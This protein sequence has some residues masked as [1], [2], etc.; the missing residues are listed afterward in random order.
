VI[1][2]RSTQPQRAPPLADT[3]AGQTGFD[4]LAFMNVVISHHLRD[5]RAYFEDEVSR[6]DRGVS[7][8]TR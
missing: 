7:D 1:S 3:S 6:I 5:H 4:D 2:G 8:K